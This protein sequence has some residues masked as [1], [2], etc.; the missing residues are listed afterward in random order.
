[1]NKW[2]KVGLRAWISRWDVEI[3]GRGRL[4]ASERVREGEDGGRE[5]GDRRNLRIRP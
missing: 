1:M 5:M 3:A 2:G 4:G